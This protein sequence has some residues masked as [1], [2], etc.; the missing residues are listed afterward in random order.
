[1]FALLEE[2]TMKRR[3]KKPR[4]YGESRKFPILIT[5]DDPDGILTFSEWCRLNRLGERTGRRI[6]KEPGGPTVTQLS[7]KRIGISRRANRAWQASRACA[8]G[9]GRVTRAPVK[10]TS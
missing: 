4:R 7:A 9:G 1:L 10:V 6:L 8:A 2:E 5:A 3:T